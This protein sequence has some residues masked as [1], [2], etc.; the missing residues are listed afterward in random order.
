MLG[1]VLQSLFNK[2]PKSAIRQSL[3]GGASSNLAAG[4]FTSSVNVIFSGNSLITVP[5]TSLNVLVGG[6]QQVNFTVADNYRNPLSGGSEIK[7]TTSGSGASA[8]TLNGDVDK[9]LPD[10]KDK[11]FTSF[12]VYAKDT[13][14]VGPSQNE[15][16]SLSIVVTSPNGNIG[17]RRTE[18]FFVMA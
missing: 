8:I 9:V 10:T 18:H 16:F 17:R 12:T 11:S 5:D 6:Q 1:L 2:R 14:A 7:V 13:N 4:I 3:W 15:N